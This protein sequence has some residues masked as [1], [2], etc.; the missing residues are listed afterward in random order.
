MSLYQNMDNN[1]N[2]MIKG[3]NDINTADNGLQAEDSTAYDMNSQDTDEEPLCLE[4][5]GVSLAPRPG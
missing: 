1:I 2:S 5:D 3:E 4:V